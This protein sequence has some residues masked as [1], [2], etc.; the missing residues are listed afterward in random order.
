MTGLLVVLILL[1][2]LTNPYEYLSIG[3]FPTL[4]VIFR[5]YSLN[6]A[7]AHDTFG[8]KRVY[9]LKVLIHLVS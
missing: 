3:D 2:T 1:D 9:S 5:G 8:N 6:N 4:G 7:H